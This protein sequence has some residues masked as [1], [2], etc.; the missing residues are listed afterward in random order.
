MSQKPER[1]NLVQSALSLVC[2]YFEKHK[3]HNNSLRSEQ[4][5]NK[6]IGLSSQK[7]VFIFRSVNFV[8]AAAF[9]SEEGLLN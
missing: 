8:T 2:K 1:P 9:F 4:V 3:F 7:K 5:G 6:L